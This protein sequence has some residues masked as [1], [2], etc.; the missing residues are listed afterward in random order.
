MNLAALIPSLSLNSPSFPIL[1]VASANM[2]DKWGISPA[3]ATDA[4]ALAEVQ[5]QATFDHLLMRAM[6]PEEPNESGFKMF[7]EL[8]L[9]GIRWDIEQPDA[10]VL[11]AKE[12]SSGKV[13][14]FIGLQADQGESKQYRPGHL[15]FQSVTNDRINQYMEKLHSL[16]QKHVEKPHLSK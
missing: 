5:Y 15:P 9:M 7:K 12:K 8:I 2:S 6:L 13:V 10:H 3:F 4:A 1:P 16:H 14:G 11:Q